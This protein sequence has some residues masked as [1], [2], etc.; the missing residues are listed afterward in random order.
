MTQLQALSY[1]RMPGLSNKLSSLN[2]SGNA[3]RDSTVHID[4]LCEKINES[5]EHLQSSGF[6][7]DLC[8]QID[9]QLTAVK[10]SLA[11]RERGLL[12]VRE[13]AA[14]NRYVATRN[15]HRNV[16]VLRY[17]LQQLQLYLKNLKVTSGTARS[18]EI[19]PLI[20]AFNELFAM[21][22]RPLVTESLLCVPDTCQVDIHV[23][24]MVEEDSVREGLYLE[25]SQLL[26]GI[27]RGDQRLQKL[28]RL[29]VFFK[30]LQ[31][32]ADG[33][34]ATGFW[35]AC[36]AFSQSIEYPGGELKPAVFSVFKQIE[37]VVMDVLG[38]EPILGIQ[39]EVDSLLCNLL[40]YIS[41][42]SY[43]AEHLQSIEDEFSFFNLVAVLDDPSD[44]Q[45]S[46]WFKHSLK[47]HW[48]RLQNASALLDENAK[49]QSEVYEQDIQSLGVLLSLAGVQGA[50]DN[51]QEVTGCLLYTSPSPRDQRGSRMPSSA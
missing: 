42:G 38:R 22:K 13:L 35:L 50:H 43:K 41:C 40:C 49:S 37:K 2:E 23:L 51:L 19:S 48:Q 3:T 12:Y 36:S 10:A 14:A 39:A 11:N 21:K 18:D 7:S 9:L 5:I 28:E 47:N 44:A 16:E 4:L 34:K 24:R 27:F 20:L 15:D 31:D 29:T 25:F 6:S 45:S 1:V 32:H 30:R 8:E 33:K 46:L 26:L 17:S